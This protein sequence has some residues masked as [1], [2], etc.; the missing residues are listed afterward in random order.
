MAFQ[1]GNFCSCQAGKWQVH[2]GTVLAHRNVLLSLL[3]H[4]SSGQVALGWLSRQT[5]FAIAMQIIC[6]LLG[7]GT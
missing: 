1:R 4:S 3:V 2:G 6:S 5:K 7:T